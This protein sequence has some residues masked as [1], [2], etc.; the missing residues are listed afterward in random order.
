M[1]KAPSK[2]IPDDFRITVEGHSIKPVVSVKLLG[3]HLDQHFVWD[4]HIDHVVKKCHG[5]LGALTK[6][7]PSLT[8]ELRRL[9]YTALI[10]SHLE[11]CS[12]IIH[13]ASRTQLGK[14]D[15]IQKIASRIICDAPRDAHAAPLLESLSLKSL[16]ERRSDHILSTVINIV[17]GNC[18]PAFKDYFQLAADETIS[19]IHSRLKMG[20][21]RFKIIGASIYNQHLQTRGNRNGSQQDGEPLCQ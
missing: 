19:A 21:K 17:S 13:S 14:L 5:L 3:L 15:V 6:A 11:Y 10:R 4:V 8:R 16:E 7:A 1:F 12:A 20:N 18:H 9:A 2:K